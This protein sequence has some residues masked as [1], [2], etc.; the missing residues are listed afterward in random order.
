MFAI[1]A[2][3]YACALVDVGERGAI[4]SGRIVGERGAIFSK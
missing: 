1:S 4:F 3:A 2:A